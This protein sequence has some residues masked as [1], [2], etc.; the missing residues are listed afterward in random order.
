MFS[1]FFGKI[2]KYINIFF[3]FKIPWLNKVTTTTTFFFSFQKYTSAYINYFVKRTFMKTLRGG[4][5]K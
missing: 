3:E 5:K 4:K 2:I 1:N